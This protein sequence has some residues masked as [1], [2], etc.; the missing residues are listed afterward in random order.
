MIETM[1]YINS[2]G[3]SHRDLKLE[4]MLINEDYN[5][6]F[7]DFGFASFSKDLL[8]QQKGTPIYIAPEIINQ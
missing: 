1:I 2:K 7:A 4:N 5:L 8:T 3:I 6:K